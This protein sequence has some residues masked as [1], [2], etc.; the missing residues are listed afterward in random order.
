[1]F[2]SLLIA[3]SLQTLPCIWKASSHKKQAGNALRLY[4]A[5]PEILGFHIFPRD[6]NEERRCYWLQLVSLGRNLNTGTA[7]FYKS[8][9]KQLAN[10]ML[11]RPLSSILTSTWSSTLW[12]WVVNCDNE[13]QTVMTA[14]LHVVH[15]KTVMLQILVLLNIQNISEETRYRRETEEI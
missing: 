1:M 3:S 9:K 10:L 15:R 5:D 6:L 14:P 13:Q 12:C 7:A 4:L 11:H 8:E 2:N